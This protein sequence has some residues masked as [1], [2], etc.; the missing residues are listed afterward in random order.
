MFIEEGNLHWNNSLSSALIS[1]IACEINCKNSSLRIQVMKQEKHLVNKNLLNV[2]LL[3]AKEW[4][5]MLAIICDNK[6]AT[7]PNMAPGSVKHSAAIFTLY[8]AILKA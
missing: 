5:F 2:S 4:V 3:A 6:L 8:M 1:F 7:K